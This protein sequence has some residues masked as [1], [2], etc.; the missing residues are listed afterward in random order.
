MP[1]VYS[2]AIGC[3]LLMMEVSIGMTPRRSH[4]TACFNADALYIVLSDF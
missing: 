2:S 3:L 4:E 1:D